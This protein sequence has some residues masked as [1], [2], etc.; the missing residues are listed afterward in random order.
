MDKVQE[1]VGKL[2]ELVS[3][4][5]RDYVTWIVKHP[6]RASD[7]ESGIKLVSYLLHGRLKQ[8]STILPELLYCSANI[9][10][11]WHDRLIQ[12]HREQQQESSSSS[13]GNGVVNGRHTNGVI[14]GGGGVS[15]PLPAEDGPARS[16]ELH[17]RQREGRE[18]HIQRIRT[19][20][21]VIDYLE[22][23]LEVSARQLWGDVGRWVV[24][25]M[26]QSIK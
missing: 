23:F 16:A 8:S 25:I 3:S 20:L 21:T 6:S 24:I 7:T 19:M 11:F 22:V 5:K 9:L 1:S 14:I 13:N 10:S 18:R 12:K 17:S 2:G 26:I 15:S 4:V